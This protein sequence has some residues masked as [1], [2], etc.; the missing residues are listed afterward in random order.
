MEY[1]E[2]SKVMFGDCYN[3]DA[4]WG[5]A[6]A[7]SWEQHICWY[8]P[9]INE[10]L[11]KLIDMGVYDWEEPNIEGHESRR[12]MRHSSAMASCLWKRIETMETKVR[13]VLH[14]LL[15]NIQHIPFH[16]IQ[17]LRTASESWKPL[18][19]TISSR[20]TMM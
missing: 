4:L 15:M 20:C 14:I 5:L 13:V 16:S 19:I 9:N 7:A 6:I 3:D 8:N 2:F 1:S 10:V 12:S 17:A 11:Y 18:Q